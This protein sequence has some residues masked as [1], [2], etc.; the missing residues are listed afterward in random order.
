MGW[1]RFH[2]NVLKGFGVNP[3]V[4]EVA[5]RLKAPLSKSGIP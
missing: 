2:E 5:E 4:G 3:A 1:N